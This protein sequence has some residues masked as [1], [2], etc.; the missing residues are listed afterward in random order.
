MRKLLSVVQENLQYLNEPF[1]QEL[2]NVLPGIPAQNSFHDDL[3]ALYEDDTKRY[4]LGDDNPLA[5]P[6]GFVPLEEFAENNGFFMFYIPFLPYALVPNELHEYPLV[7]VT[8]ED[9]TKINRQMPLDEMMYLP[10]K[11]FFEKHDFYLLVDKERPLICNAELIPKSQRAGDFTV[12]FKKDE[13]T[14]KIQ[15]RKSSLCG[16]NIQF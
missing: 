7:Q 12:R 6:K 9:I 4:F 5:S 15:Y 11:M 1:I 10:A 2:K 8:S 3:F 14:Y 13:D 16:L